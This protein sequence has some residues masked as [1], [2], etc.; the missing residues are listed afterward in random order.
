MGKKQCECGSYLFYI[1]EL[2]EEEIT[3]VCT[4]EENEGASNHKALIH[5]NEQTGDI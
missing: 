2:R 1:Y 5:K 3:I 4:R